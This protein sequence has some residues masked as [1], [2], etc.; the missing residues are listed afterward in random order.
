MWLPMS[1]TGDMLTAFPKYNASFPKHY[2]AGDPV[3]QMRVVQPISSVRLVH[4]I[5]DPL[6]GKIRDAVIREL[7]PINVHYDRPTR[8]L[9]WRRIVP[10]LNVIIPWPKKSEL[11][12]VKNECDTPRPDV[13]ERTYVPTL[14]RPPMPVTVI[15][16][17]RNRYSIFRTRH[18]P[19]YIAQKE[20]EEA[21]KQARKKSTQSMLL[22]VQEYNR[23]LREQRRALGQP[24]LSEEMLAKI[25][26][27]IE[28]TRLQRA[29]GQDTEVDRVASLAEKLVI[30]AESAEVAEEEEQPRL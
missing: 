20:A 10:G 12:K 3:A 29:L 7:Q 25:G 9:S 5:P 28:K 14:L 2:I 16:E 6:T 24:V 19:E 27:V 18:T 1:P 26:E 4:P 21:E 23:K 8:V 11:E 15:D 22:P 13:E 17:L 30:Q